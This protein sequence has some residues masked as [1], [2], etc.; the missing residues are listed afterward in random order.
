MSLRS[1]AD[2]RNQLQEQMDE[3]A[4]LL[5]EGKSKEAFQKVVDGSIKGRA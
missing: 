4:R 1:E 5:Q 3:M 2:I